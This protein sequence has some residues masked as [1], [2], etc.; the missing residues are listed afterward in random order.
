MRSTPVL[1]AALAMLAGTAAQAQTL[2]VRPA[3]FADPRPATTARHGEVVLGQTTV[4]AA[5]RMFA[6]ELAADSVRVSR[7]HAGNPAP[8]N[9]RTVW[10]VAAHEVQPRQRLDLGPDLYSLYFDANERLIAAVT[11]Q[12]PAG[13]T[14][15][16]L[17]G[18]YP[19]LQQGRRWHSGD[20]PHMDEWTATLG[21]CVAM[22]AQ[23]SV[24]TQRVE[25]LSYVYTCPTKPAGGP[26]TTP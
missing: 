11:R 3:R 7:G 25:Q 23:V 24:G 20:Q 16:T 22:A 5:L 2:N 15:A 1:V 26:R 19:T 17:A 6:E 8:E 13:L 18:H 4:T 21:P 12:V 14:R 9:P 10:Q